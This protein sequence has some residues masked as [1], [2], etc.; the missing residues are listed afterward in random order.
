[1]YSIPCCFLRFSQSGRAGLRSR[2]CSN[3]RTRKWCADIPMCL[4]RNGRAPRR[5]PT[6]TGKRR[7]NRKDE[8]SPLRKRSAPCWLRSGRCCAMSQRPQASCNVPCALSRAT[9]PD[10][11]Q[12]AQRRL[13]DGPSHPVPGQGNRQA[14]DQAEQQIWQ[15]WIE[16]GKLHR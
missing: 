6:G 11:Y 3:R 13:V 16:D 4:G 1:M 7:N 12:A 9:Q 10:A 2:R 15:A 5:K 14:D 8:P